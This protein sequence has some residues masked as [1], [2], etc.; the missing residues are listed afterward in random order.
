[1]SNF[2]INWTKLDY[3]GSFTSPLLTGVHDDHFDE[4]MPDVDIPDAEP[5]PQPSV[6][7]SSSSVPPTDRNDAAHA[8]S[9]SPV[10]ADSPSPSPSQ[11]YPS[12][13]KPA[14]YGRRSPPSVNVT[15]FMRLAGGLGL[16]SA[17][18]GL[19]NI[20]D[21]I[22]TTD[23]EVPS[24]RAGGESRRMGN[25]RKAAAISRSAAED[26]ALLT[27]RTTSEHH[28]ADFLSTVAN[29]IHFI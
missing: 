15:Q 2:I 3:V 11:S 24:E 4:D 22:G 27:C 7:A 23:W 8:D 9:P 21:S 16:A 6:P 12:P 19:D 29:V 26:F 17:I 20:T 25:K 10:H 1:M 5:H 13:R 14:R 28:A 18:S